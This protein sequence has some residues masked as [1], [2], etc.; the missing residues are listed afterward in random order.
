[1]GDLTP[2]ATPFAAH[3]H[4]TFDPSL[5]P[6]KAAGLRGLV[7][8]CATSLGRA[9]SAAQLAP[10]ARPEGRVEIV[11]TAHVTNAVKALAKAV[12]R[13]L[14]AQQP[15]TRA[16]AGLGGSYL[17]KDDSGAPAAIIKPCDEE[18]MAP[19]NPRG[20]VGRALGDPGLK[21]SV[22]V[23]EAAMR[24][25]AAYLLDGGRAGVPPTVLVRVSHP[26]FYVAAAEREKIKAHAATTTTRFTPSLPAVPGT[27]RESG[28]GGAVAAT[29]G[30]DA[31]EVS[32]ARAAPSPPRAPLGSLAAALRARSVSG[33]LSASPVREPK[34]AS[35]QRYVRHDCDASEI[36]P[37]SFSVA[38]VH[39]I[40]ILDIRILN[41]DRHAGNLLVTR[42]RGSGDGGGSS[43]G[44]RPP[45]SLPGAGHRLVPIDHG[46]AL[47]ECLEAPYW[48]WLYYSQAA[49]KF[50]DET[51]AYIASINIDADLALLRREL[52]SLH[53]GSLRVLWLGTT[54]LQR[55]AAAGLTLAEIGAALSRPLVGMEEEASPVEELAWAARREAESVASGDDGP[56]LMHRAATCP[57]PSSSSARPAFA[58]AELEHRTDAELLFAL[59][60][61]SEG[62]S[63]TLLSPAGSP[64]TP[65]GWR[66][67]RKG[68]DTPLA[69]G[70]TSIGSSET[71][72]PSRPPT[73]T[74]LRRASVGS[75]AL[76]SA[77]AALPP[78]PSARL[79]QDGGAPASP[80]GWARRGGRR[81]T[82][83]PPPVVAAGSALPLADLPPSTW[84][85]FQES[86]IAGLDA[87][88]AAGAWRAGK[89]GGD[90]G[91][92]CP[93]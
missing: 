9:P 40:G 88:L 2:P 38:D 35:A 20:Y 73:T 14:R 49:Q 67:K 68:L 87:A 23:G 90:L 76:R 1:M 81:G 69:S 32:T 34:L 91:A 79:T 63:S 66:T 5:T 80:A 92:S 7:A 74:A 89:G 12:V 26:A 50:S 85:L 36:G 71:A 84:A 65:A 31:S 25:V 8:I 29:P 70:R 56:V 27:P 86:F 52:P 19:N 45:L 48:E 42:S 93:V 21:K 64:A 77:S 41:T 61:G 51:L 16:A 37:S 62:G 4:T 57:T 15:V 43:R 24:E 46:F 28:D 17:F 47:P 58:A 72:V 11:G 82:A 60:A 13:G 55:G 18:P 39:A 78:K 53:V 10:A 75:S 54:L 30:T 59:D 33:D 22:R 83:Y 3:A 44:R 6:A